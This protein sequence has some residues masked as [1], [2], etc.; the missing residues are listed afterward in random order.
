MTSARL[1]PNAGCPIVSRAT[2]LGAQPP[3]FSFSRF[4]ELAQ[5]W[6]S[7]AKALIASNERMTPDQRAQAIR[8][9]DVHSCGPLPQRRMRVAMRRAG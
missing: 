7:R 6:L 4:P 2:E 5:A 3:A 1:H 9:C 8:E